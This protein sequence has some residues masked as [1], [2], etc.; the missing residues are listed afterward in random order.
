MGSAIDMEKKFYGMEKQIYNVENI[1]DINN[2]LQY[3][4]IYTIFTII[5][6]T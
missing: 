5:S 2:I 4:E 1:S 6:A 3:T